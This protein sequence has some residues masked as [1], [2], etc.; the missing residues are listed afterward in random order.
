MAKKCD[1]FV[2]RKYSFTHRNKRN[3]VCWLFLHHNVY[4]SAPDCDIIFIM[5]QNFIQVVICF[6]VFSARRL[7]YMRVNSM[8]CVVKWNKSCENEII[9]NYTVQQNMNILNLNDR[10]AAVD[11]IPPDRLI[12]TAH[13]T[14]SFESSDDPISPGTQYFTMF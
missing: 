11:K 14:S 7:I 5:H 1:N 6:V 12:R 9:A 8:W 4:C 3:S 13:L 2:W 10:Y